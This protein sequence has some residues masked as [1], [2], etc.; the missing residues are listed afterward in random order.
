MMMKKEDFKKITYI[1]V[2]ILFIVISVMGLF[3]LPF[4]QKIYKEQLS[5]EVKEELRTY[6]MMIED[7]I[8][9]ALV[10]FLLV[11][12]NHETHARMAILLRMEVVYS[13]HSIS[14]D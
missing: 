3:F 10:T 11:E 7:E 8:D 2:A 1:V 6:T 12:K 9:E 13:S 4:F 5:N 14:L